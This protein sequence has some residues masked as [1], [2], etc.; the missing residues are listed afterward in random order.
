MLSDEKWNEYIS[1][2]R[3]MNVPAKTVLLHE[4]EVSKKLFLVEKGCVCGRRNR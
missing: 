3:R 2:F 4:G 1:C